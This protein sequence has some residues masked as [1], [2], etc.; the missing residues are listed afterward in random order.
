MESFTISASQ[1]DNTNL[2]KLKALMLYSPL[3][4]VDHLQA[5]LEDTLIKQLIRT[6]RSLR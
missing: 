2:A 1:T 4:E 6:Y 3:L 5:I